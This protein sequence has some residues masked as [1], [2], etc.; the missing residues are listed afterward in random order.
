MSNAELTGRTSRVTLAYCRLHA[1]YRCRQSK[2]LFQL[3]GVDMRTLLH[4]IVAVGRTFAD[5]HSSAT[6]LQTARLPFIDVSALHLPCTYRPYCILRG[7]HTL[8][9]I[10]TPLFLPRD[11]YTQRG[12]RRLCRR[13]ISVCLLVCPSVTRRYCIKTAK[14]II[15]LFSPPPHHSNF[16]MFRPLDASCLSVVSFNSTIRRAHS[17]VIT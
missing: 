4:G 3:I 13:K 5:S 9:S 12:L 1:L 17:S 8:W 11:G 6:C 14:R 16:A 7:Q 2:Q 15:T 10:K